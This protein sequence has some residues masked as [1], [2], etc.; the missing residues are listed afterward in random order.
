MFN[1]YKITHVSPIDY[2]AEELRKY[3]KMMMPDGGDF[4]VFYDDTWITYTGRQVVPL[5][6]R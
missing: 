4:D 2:A 1:I 3:L 6:W 5:L